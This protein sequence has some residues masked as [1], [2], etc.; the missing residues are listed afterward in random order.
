MGAKWSKINLCCTTWNEM[1]LTNW[2]LWLCCT[3]TGSTFTTLLSSLA[4]LSCLCA[5]AF[6]PSMHALFCQLKWGKWIKKKPE[7]IYT[8]AAVYSV[9]LTCAA[10][11]TVSSLQHSCAPLTQSEVSRKGLNVVSKSIPLCS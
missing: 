2:K 11:Y 4:L 3:G 9:L 5:K 10:A 8:S 7:K 6:C 1:F